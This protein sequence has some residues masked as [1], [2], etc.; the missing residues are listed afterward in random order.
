M[1]GIPYWK[2]PKSTKTGSIYWGQQKCAM[3]VLFALSYK[4]AYLSHFSKQ[5][6]I[7]SHAKI[8]LQYKE[9]DNGI[10]AEQK[11]MYTALLTFSE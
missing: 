2:K 3:L 10:I 9:A 5:T 1:N 7:V 4:S 8:E 11:N 6:K